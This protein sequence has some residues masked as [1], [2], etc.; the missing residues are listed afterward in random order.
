MLLPTSQEWPEEVYPAYANGPGYVL[1]SDVVDFIMSEFKKQ[2][3]TV[4]FIIPCWQKKILPF[5][6]CNKNVAPCH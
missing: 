6:H 5:N 1:S 4:P 2:G 3:L